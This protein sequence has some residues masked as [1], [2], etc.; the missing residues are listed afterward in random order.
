M[1]CGLVVVILCLCGS[2]LMAFWTRG[3]VQVSSAEFACF[4]V[5]LLFNG[6]WSTSSVVLSATNNHSGLALRY[7]IGSVLAGGLCLL[8][9]HLFGVVGAPF[10]LLILDIILITYVLPASC[11]VLGD[12]LS[13][14]IKDILRMRELR[15]SAAHLLLG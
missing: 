1:V 10:S 5:P 11:K 3:R 4:A 8:L 12:P 9:V 2:W 13:E 14:V 15:R 7:F 6:I